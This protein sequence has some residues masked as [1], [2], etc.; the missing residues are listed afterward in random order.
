MSAYVAMEDGAAPI[1]GSNS[2]SSK[3]FAFYARGGL[4]LTGY[5]VSLVGNGVYK[6]TASKVGAGSSAAFGIYKYTTQSA[7]PFRSTRF[8]LQVNPSSNYIKSYFVDSVA[9]YNWGGLAESFT[10]ISYGQ[11]ALSGKKIVCI[12][13][14]LTAGNYPLHL[15]T[16]FPEA[17]VVDAGTAGNTVA[18]MLARFPAD[19]LAQSPDYICYFGCVNSI[20]GDDP[21]AEIN[22]DIDAMIAAAGGIPMVIGTGT[23]FGAQANW[24]AGRQA[25]MDAVNAHILSHSATNVISKLD[26][27]TPLLAV[28]S[29]INLV[30]SA[31]ATPGEGLH[32]NAAGDRI[33]AGLFHHG[34]NLL[35]SPLAAVSVLGTE[36]SPGVIALNA[37]PA[38]EPADV[39]NRWFAADH[40]ANDVEPTTIPANAGDKIFKGP[41]GLLMYSTALTGNDITR[42]ERYVN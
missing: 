15:K 13:D 23:P 8:H 21:A 31:E 32:L 19:V 35:S 22:A 38:L 4:I 29:E 26:L 25:V 40:T 5:T 10:P 41:S 24:T 6:V 17:T 16:I 42:A 27:F 33:V 12:G 30:A 7:R 18:Q 39:D 34:L 3:D 20:I 28:G 2:D 11:N 1:P 14:S 9:L 36:L 37:P